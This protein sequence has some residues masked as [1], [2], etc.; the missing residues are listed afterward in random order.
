MVLAHLTQGSGFHSAL[1]T[2]FETKQPPIDVTEAVSQLWTSVS[3]PLADIHHDTELVEA[4]IV[5]PL[6]HYKGFVDCVSLF[7]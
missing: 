7:R 1:Q 5:H 4:P 3:G 2:F 6:L